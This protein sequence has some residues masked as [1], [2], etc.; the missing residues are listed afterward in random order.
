MT[1]DIDLNSMNYYELEPENNSFYDIVVDITHRCNM[2]CK[3]CYV[4]NRF[5]PDMRL[6]EYT[7]F[8][9]KLPK[10]VMLRIVGAEPTLHP[11]LTEFIRIGFEHGHNCILITNGLRLASQP[12]VDKVEATGL[13]HVYMSLNGIDNDD[14]YEQIDEMRCAT[15]KI[16]AFINCKDKFNMNAGIILVKGINEEAPRAAFDLITREKVPDIT[17]RF[18]NVG[19]LG[20]YQKDAD[21]NLKMADMVKLCADQLGFTEDYIWSHYGKPHRY[22]NVVEPGTIEFPLDPNN[23]ERYQ[24]QWVKI[25]DWDTDN[26][27]GI[28]DPGSVRRGRVTKDW[29]VAPFYEHVKMNEG[30]Y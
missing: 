11:E 7:K 22:S 19:Q 10:P 4:P 12:F 26:E 13:K 8:V 16:K 25:T 9:A 14:W 27:V 24:G 18:K 1:K 6:A 2:E 23:K 30:G 17:L 5:I 15:K 20:R 3:N 28:P 21:E 29:K